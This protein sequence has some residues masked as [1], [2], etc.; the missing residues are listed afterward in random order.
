MKLTKSLRDVILRQF[1]SGD[2]MEYLDK[3][4]E[5]KPGR[6]EQIVRQVMIEIDDRMKQINQVKPDGKESHGIDG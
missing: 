5:L 2:D 6:T 4:Y 1:K 3:L